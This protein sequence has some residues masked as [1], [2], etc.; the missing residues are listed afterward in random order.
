MSTSRR[1]SSAAMAP[2]TLCGRKVRKGDTMIIPRYAPH[3][4]HIL[5]DD[6]DTFILERFENANDMPRYAYLPFSNGPHICS[7]AILAIKDPVIIL[8]K[9]LK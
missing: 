4:H 7:G 3:R 5:L 2:E 6:Q 8:A 9:V 1:V